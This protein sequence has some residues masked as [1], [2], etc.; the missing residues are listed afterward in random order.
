MRL[1]RLVLLCLAALVLTGSV[2]ARV[3]AGPA[4]PQGLRAFLLRPSEAVTHEFARTPSF[5]WLPVRGAVRYEFE[6]SKNAGFTEAGTFWSD[7]KLKSPAVS[8]PVAL[9]WMTGSPYAVYARVR[10]ITRDGVSPWSAS[11]GFNVRWNSVPQPIQ[12]YPGMSRWSV[13][14]GATSYQVW[15]PAL[16]KIVGMRTNAVDHREFYAFHQQAGYSGTVNW[17]VRA[18]R[19]LY[20]KIPTGLPTVSYGPWSA[21]YTTT[22]PALAGGTVGPSV[23]TADATVSTSTTAALHELTPG[24]AFA[25]T[26]SGAGT[27]ADLYRVYVFSDADCVNVIHRGSIVASPAYVPRTT[28]SLKLPLTTADVLTASTSYLKD[29]KKGESEPSQFMFDSAKVASTESDPEPAKQAATPAPSTGTSSGG[30]PAGDDPSNTPPENDPSL[31]ATPKSTGAPVDLWDSGWPNG[32]FYWTVVPVR[33]ESADPKQTTTSAASAPGA[34]SFRLADITGFAAGQLLRIGAGATEETLTIVSV[35]TANSQVSTTT[36]ATYAHGSGEHVQ[37]L[38]ATIDYWDLELPQDVCS[39]GRVQAFGKGS[40]PLVAGSTAP[41]VS[42]LSPKGRLTSAATARPSFYGSPL[43][44]WEPALGADQYQVQW[45]K[46]RYPWVKAGEK[47]TFAT[48]A[49][50]TLEPGVWYYRVRGVNFSLPGTARAMSWSAPVGLRVAKP[51]FA[52]VKKSGR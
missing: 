44:A 39:A 11:F 43:I 19:S 5:S 26:R 16:R 45:S 3:A 48:S 40:T 15:F 17:R 33:F 21:T 23:A 8:V 51:T 52:V 10:A 7:E 25:G 46:T 6:L 42:G 24:F 49:L 30:T 31:P 4:A 32:R 22:N 38:T 20:G 1:A 9:P 14:G 36:S 50:L 41:F 34:S 12:T 18:V 13:V 29:L 35:D 28:G 27:S 37:N 47:F 2:Q